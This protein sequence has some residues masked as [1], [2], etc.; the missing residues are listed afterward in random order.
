LVYVTY[1][2]VTNLRT[3]EKKLFSVD[4]V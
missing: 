4:L 1:A 3:F 2:L